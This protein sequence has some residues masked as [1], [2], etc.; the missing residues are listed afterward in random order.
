MYPFFVRMSVVL[1]AFLAV[2]AQAGYVYFSAPAPFMIPI[3]MNNNGAAIGIWDDYHANK[4]RGFIRTPDGTFT[5]FDPP[6]SIETT[7]LDVNEKNLVVGTYKE[8]ARGFDRYHGFIRHAHGSIEM[9]DAP[10][11]D[12]YT[13]IIGVNKKGTFTGYYRDHQDHTHG[14][15]QDAAGN[16]T[17]FVPPG[18]G[19]TWPRTIGDDG[20]VTGYYIHSGSG[21]CGIIYGGFVRAPDGTITTFDVGNSA[22]PEGVNS[23]GVDGGDYST[24]TCQVNGFLRQADGTTASFTYP[25]SCCTY[26]SGMNEHGTIVGHYIDTASN[27]ARSY[28]RTADGTITAF[29]PGRQKNDS[30]AVSINNRG[31]VLG[32]YDDNT[33][34]HGFIYTP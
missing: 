12:G 30:Q 5:T 7:P 21:G 1:L 26:V 33:G 20:K 25:G 24:D 4:T 15:V 8:N 17:S 27:G 34:I 9:Y 23:L 10:D 22:N 31:Q 3:R 18:G 28:Q 32:Y 19:G 14:F 16:F 13:V 2:P 29:K 6:A 11:S